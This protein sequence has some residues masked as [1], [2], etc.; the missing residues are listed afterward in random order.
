MSKQ[1]GR[2]G[3]Q[4]Q[5]LPQ[6]PSSSGNDDSREHVLHFLFD[7]PAEPVFLPKGDNNA[8]FDLP[9]DYIVN[10][11]LFKH[12]DYCLNDPIQTYNPFLIG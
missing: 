12:F 10:I 9:T 6:R 11:F 8:L 7:R 4:R 2:G 5:Q 1:S 3:G